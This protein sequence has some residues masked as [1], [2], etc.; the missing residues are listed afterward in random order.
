M[1]ATDVLILKGL[2]LLLNDANFTKRGQWR[3]TVIRSVKLH[4]K[5]IWGD[6]EIPPIEDLFPE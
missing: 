5:E 2:W 1:N 4:K 6:M 3:Q